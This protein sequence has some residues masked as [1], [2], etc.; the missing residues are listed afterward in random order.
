MLKNESINHPYIN[1]NNFPIL[2]ISSSRVKKQK[3]NSVLRILSSCAEGDKSF[4]SLRSDYFIFVELQSPILK[5]NH[6]FFK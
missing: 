6:Q 2:T 1:E 4:K 5:Q 3:R